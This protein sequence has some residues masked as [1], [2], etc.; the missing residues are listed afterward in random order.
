MTAVNVGSAYSVFEL[1]YQSL[2]EGVPAIE[3][4][5]GR[6]RQQTRTPIAVSVDGARAAQGLQQ[7][8]RAADQA[9]RQ[10][11]SLERT[12]DRT[13]D[14]EI[15]AARAA[16]DHARALALTGEALQRAEQGSVRYNNLLAQQA[17]LERQ[18]ARE[19]A[20]AARTPKPASAGGGALGE[21]G[22]AVGFVGGAGGAVFAVRATADFAIEQ[23]KAALALDRTERAARALTG[24]QDRYSELVRLA[25][26]NQRLFGGSLQENIANLTGFAVAARRSGVEIATLD[27]LS[28]RLNILSPEQGAEGAA[29][30]INEALSGNASS[31]VR[32]YEIPRELLKG[33]EDS[34][35]G[36]ADKLKILDDALTKSGVTAAAVKGA[37]GDEVIAYNE[38]GAAVERVKLGLG[39]LASDGF[40]PAARGGALILN[41][42]TQGQQGAQ[43]FYRQI[44]GLS[45]EGFGLLNAT[46]ARL[47]GSQ[48]QA[49]VAT[50]QATQAIASATPAYI[51]AQQAQSSYNRSIQEAVAVEQAQQAELRKTATEQAATAI[52]QQALNI[53]LDRAKQAA[54]D[55]ANGLFATGQGASEAGIQALLAAGKI[56]ALTAANLRLRNAQAA[57]LKTPDPID[58]R[59]SALR[60]QASFAS[61]R[62]REEAKALKEAQQGYTQATETAAQRVARLRRERDQLTEGTSKYVQK[63]TELAVAEKAL[64][65][66]QTRTG[67]SATTAANRAQREAAAMEKADLNLLDSGQRLLE[68]RE[69]I[70]RLNPKSLEYKQTAKE[71]ADLEGKI[72]D[73]QERQAKALVDARLGELDDR[74]RRRAEARELATAQRVL[75]SGST[76]EEQKAAARDVLERIPLEQAKRALDIAGKQRDAGGSAS[77]TA[78]AVLAGAGRRGV[79]TAPS[80]A[81]VLAGGVGGVAPS[82]A[83]PGGSVLAQ[84]VAGLSQV[85]FQAFIDGAPAASRVLVGLRNGLAAAQSAT[86][87]RGV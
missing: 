7:T 28:K 27:D 49:A 59:R 58:D 83:A 4:Q 79:S 22:G 77:G 18:A 20:A 63:Q 67:R 44:E 42:F 75:A 34:S 39:S 86:P 3:Q 68:L 72:A 40:A 21:I 8:G 2:T 37:I 6:L 73:E 65:A 57:D 80:A 85:Q 69:K 33:I 13:R 81:A 38:L 74:K 29:I 43:A 52:N 51:G 82:G 78:A 32:R 61:Q 10:F 53:E 54:I 19:A 66:Q 46:S 31:L 50:R 41:V 26:Q 5:L 47:F 23:G 64:E 71:I 30:A 16:G 35:K 14:S 12:F 48:Q 11:Q 1:R 36:A 60:D 70:G 76:S 17:T 84:I 45:N 25:T 55:A 87:Q 15:R 9:L 62:A 56:D 24:T